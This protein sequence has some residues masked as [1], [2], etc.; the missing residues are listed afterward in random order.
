MLWLKQIG[1]LSAV[2]S[3]IPWSS[4]GMEGPRGRLESEPF[5]PLPP[6]LFVFLEGVL[7]FRLLI[8]FSKLSIRCMA[9]E[10][11][12]EAASGEGVG[13]GALREVLEE[14][15]PEDPCK[16]DRCSRTFK[17]NIASLNSFS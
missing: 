7:R 4:A 17:L 9:R 5:L 10:R 12:T 13:C 6:P 1:W 14:A 15:V 11:A 3:F 8:C 16:G 2:L